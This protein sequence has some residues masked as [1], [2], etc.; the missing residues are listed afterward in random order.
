[1]VANCDGTLSSA[2]NDVDNTPNTN[3]KQTQR[4]LGMPDE[5][6]FIG[7]NQDRCFAVAQ[8]PTARLDFGTL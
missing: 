4:R 3:N 6:P 8:I 5:S 7:T 1:M 2:A